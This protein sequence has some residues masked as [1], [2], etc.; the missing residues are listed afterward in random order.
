MMATLSPAL[1]VLTRRAVMATPA[2]RVKTTRRPSAPGGTGR[3]KR[4]ALQRTTEAW[5]EKLSTR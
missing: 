4:R 5:R 2:M 1:A 3:A